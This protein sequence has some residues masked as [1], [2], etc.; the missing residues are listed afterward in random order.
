MGQ[1]AA[2]RWL[3]WRKSSL[4]EAGNCVEVAA[5]GDQVFLRDSKHPNGPILS[6]SPTQW[7]GFRLAVLSGRLDLIELAVRDD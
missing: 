5:L 6:L 2:R 3:V 4:S 7:A 1:T